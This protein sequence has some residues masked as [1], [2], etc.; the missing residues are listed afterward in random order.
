MIEDIT[1]FESDENST[2]VDSVASSDDDSEFDMESGDEDNILREIQTDSEL[3]AFVSRLQEAHDQMQ[4]QQRKERLHI[5]E[6]Q[7]DQNRDGRQKRKGQAGFPSITKY[8]Q[9]QSDKE[10]SK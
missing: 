8:F 6:I 7:R 3:L 1:D 4:W 2:P 10:V 9:K 5:W